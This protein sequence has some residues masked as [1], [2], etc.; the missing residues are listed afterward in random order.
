MVHEAADRVQRGLNFAIVDEVDSILIDEARTPLIIS[1][2]AE[3]HTDMYLAMNRVVPLLTVQAGEADPHTGEGITKPGDFTIDE[4][5]HQVFL[6][7]LG[8]ENA[9]KIL[10]NLGLIAEGASLYDPAN[11]SLMH[12]LYAA[13]RAN[14]LYHRDQH[15]VVQQGEIV[16]VDEF[17]GRLMTGRRWSDCLHQAV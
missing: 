6:T 14:H 15:Y 12:H 1:G 9:E 11:I 8:H 2:Q 4:K 5:S 7:E 10:F 16:I 3:D 13:L 17:T